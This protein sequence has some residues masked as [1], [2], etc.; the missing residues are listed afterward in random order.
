[1]SLT[2]SQQKALEY[3]KHISLT[4]NAGSGKTFVLIQR[5]LKILVDENISIRNIAAITFTEKAASELYTKIAQKLDDAITTATEPE[6]IARLENLRK[7]L[8]SS[9]ISTIHSFCIDILREFPV[10]AGIDANFITIDTKRAREL[11]QLSVKEALKEK[12][13]TETYRYV[14]RLPWRNVKF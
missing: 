13:E 8:I 6:K 2:T 9:N 14:I 4:A 3:H 12:D 1:M 7:Q 5:F 11:L 10:E